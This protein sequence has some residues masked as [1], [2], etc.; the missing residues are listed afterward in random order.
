MSK[1]KRVRRGP[2]RQC[3]RCGSPYYA[4]PAVLAKGMG[5][6]CSKRCSNLANNPASSLRIPPDI[7]D[8]IIEAYKD[9]ASKQKAGEPFGYGRGGVDK[10]LKRR[11]VKPRTQDESRKGVPRALLALGI[12]H[13]YEA[14]RIELPELERSYLPDFYLPER[15]LYVEVKGWPNARWEAVLDGLAARPDVRLLIIDRSNYPAIKADPSA[16]P[17][18][19][20][21]RVRCFGRSYGSLSE[22]TGRLGHTVKALL[23]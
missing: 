6:Y 4:R 14:R 16:L 8:R 21:P 2:N 12:V 23:V 5:R 18:E 22:A 9:G 11:G 15:D 10:V 17:T 7:E 3:D 13:E 1:Q 19:L 20:S